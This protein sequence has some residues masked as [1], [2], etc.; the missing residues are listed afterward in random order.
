[1]TTFE[2]W[3]DALNGEANIRL[4]PPAVRDKM[5]TLARMAYGG[6]YGTAIRDARGQSSEGDNERQKRI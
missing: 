4:E 2:Q 6:G 5:R 3:W 1:M